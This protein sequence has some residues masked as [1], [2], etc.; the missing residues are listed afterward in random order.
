MRADDRHGAERPGHS[1]PYVDRIDEDSGRFSYHY[2][3]NDPELPTNRAVRRAFQL[4]VPLIFFVGVS[5]GLYL[6]I[7][8]A[9]VTGD[10]PAALAFTVEADVD[11]RDLKPGAA[12]FS[13]APP[14]AT[15]PPVR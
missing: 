1:A 11:T 3:R 10:D 5:K 7:R 15:T 8:P 12:D 2:E 4:G 6:A 13:L 9:Y 14:P